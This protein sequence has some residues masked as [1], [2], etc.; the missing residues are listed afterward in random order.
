[1]NQILNSV[2]KENFRQNNDNEARV[3]EFGINQKLNNQIIQLKSKDK[4]TLSP[5]I[6]MGIILGSFFSVGGSIFTG[7]AIGPIVGCVFCLVLNIVIVDS[8]NQELES[9]KESMRNAAL[10]E[11]HDAY[12]KSDEKTKNQIFQ[13]DNEVK[14]YF[15]K[16]IR[17]ADAIGPMVDHVT[18][19]LQRMISHADAGSNMRFVEAEL[20]YVVYMTGISF[21]FKSNYTNP[22]DNYSFNKARYRDLN[23]NTECEGLAQALAKLTIVK[24]KSFYPPNSLTI[25]VSHIDAAVTLH[26]KAANKNFIPARDII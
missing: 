17:N 4:F 24:M 12:I 15:V 26:F 11:I 9:K 25:S 5:F 1:M 2:V 7:F 10:A 6:I 14:A 20:K 3:I 13:Y 19:M 16:V 23:L 8:F 18:S 22:Q 21:Y